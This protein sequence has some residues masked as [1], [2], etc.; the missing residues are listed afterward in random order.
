MDFNTGGG[1]GDTASPGGSSG[2]TGG[3]PPTMTGG[4][5]GDFDYRDPVQSFIRTVTSV[6]TRPAAFF[7]G[8]QRRGDFINPLVFALICA[9]I[10]AVLAGIVSFF[11]ALAGGDQGVGAAL[12]SLIGTIVV[13]PI[14]SAVGLFIGA[15]IFHLLVILLVR[16]SNAGFEAT[17]RVSAYASVTQLVAWIPIIGFIVSLYGLYLGIVGIREVHSTTTGRAALVV[18]IPA[19]IVILFVLLV[20]AAV[21]AFFIS[22]Q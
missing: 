3:A 8:I 6:V 10:S 21:A 11:F 9:V 13:T 16:P 7:N 4:T 2:G 19:A 14:L 22:Q 18:L 5:G 20:F 12:G 15:G 1:T 17:F